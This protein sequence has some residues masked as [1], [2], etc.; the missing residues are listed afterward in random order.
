MAGLFGVEDSL[1][2]QDCWELGDSLCRQD[3][4]ELGDPL[5][6]QDCSELGHSPEHVGP[7]RAYQ[8]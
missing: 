7:A 4:S 1:R 5:R 3:Y 6:R 2:R 8:G